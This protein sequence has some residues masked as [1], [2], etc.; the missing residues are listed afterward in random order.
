M[1]D[2]EAYARA[3]ARAR[4]KV[5]LYKQGAY[6]LLVALLLLAINLATYRGHWW[7]WW[8][9]LGLTLLFGLR[10]FK[11]WGRERFENLEQRM[12]QE[13]LDREERTRHIVDD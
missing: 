7:F 9:L 13:E 4:A 11:V 8:P 12:I 3:A 1:A 5:G 2:Q 10:V 6:S